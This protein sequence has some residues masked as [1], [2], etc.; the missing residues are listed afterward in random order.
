[1]KFPIPNCRPWLA[2]S[3]AKLAS[4]HTMG[5]ERTIGVYEKTKCIL[6]P[7]KKVLL[8]SYMSKRSNLSHP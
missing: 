1:M 2:I 7:F 4:P 3:F 5:L 6:C 8:S